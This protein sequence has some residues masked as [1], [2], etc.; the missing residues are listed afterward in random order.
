MTKLEIL[1]PWI[2]AHEGGY[3]NNPH[4]K[5]GATNKGVTIATWRAYGY[6]KNGDGKIDQKDV[7]LISNEDATKIMRRNFWNPWQGDNIKSQSIANMLVDWVWA[8]GKYGITIP[9]QLLGVKADGKVGSITIAKL[10]QQN[11]EAFFKKLKARRRD[12]IMS[13]SKPGTRNSVF[14]NGWLNRLA[15]IGYGELTYP[16]GKKVTFKG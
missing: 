14:R 10:N 13:I 1:A 12:Y 15:R 4:D 9:Q 16:N 7:K 11:P 2:L 8:S 6:D 5:G 3:A